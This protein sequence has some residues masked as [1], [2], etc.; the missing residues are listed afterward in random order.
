MK[1]V[2]LRIQLTDEDYT[3]I[4]SMAE[5]LNCSLEEVLAKCLAEGL[6]E[7]EWFE[8]EVREKLTIEYTRLQLKD[9]IP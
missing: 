6:S 8:D 1:Q 3:E 9:L 7:R 4:E 2:V 5:R